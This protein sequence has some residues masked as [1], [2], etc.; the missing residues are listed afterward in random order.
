MI[1]HSII[2]RSNAGSATVGSIDN[3]YQDAKDDYYS[4]ENQ[5]SEWQGK[6]AVDLGLNGSVNKQQFIDLLAGKDPNNFKNK[7]R[8]NSFKKK[9]D[10]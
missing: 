6:L 8:D 10:R 1:S 7:L 3:Y 9:N 2:T 5:P 4:K